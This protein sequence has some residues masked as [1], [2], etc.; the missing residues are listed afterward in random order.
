MWGY[1]LT[2]ENLVPRDPG[3]KSK[4]GELAARYRHHG[5]DDEQVVSLSQEFAADALEDHIRRVVDQAPALSAAQRD[6]LAAL[7]R[8]PSAGGG[9]A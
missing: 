9:A 2:A 4:R 6:R 1:S 3:W 5:A 7:L 8:A